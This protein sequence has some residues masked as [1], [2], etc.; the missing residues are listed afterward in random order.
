V[1]G[2]VQFDDRIAQGGGPLG[3]HDQDDGLR[4]IEPPQPFGVPY[5]SQLPAD[6]EGLL[7]AGR[8]CS[9]S[10]A[11]GAIRHMGTAMALGQAAGTAAAI[12]ARS[13]V[14]PRH[15]RMEELHAALREAGAVIDSPVV[16]SIGQA[17]PG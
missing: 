9:A 14:A 17:R 10:G 7:V 16:E 5:R 3:V 1:L 13:G 15:V 2:S 8:C 4:L 6:V 12:C 11:T